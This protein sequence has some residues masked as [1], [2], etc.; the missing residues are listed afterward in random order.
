MLHN[1]SLTCHLCPF[2]T[3]EGPVEKGG[4]SEAQGASGEEQ[5]RST[6]GGGQEEG[7][8]HVGELPAG[9][10]EQRV[11]FALTCFNKVLSF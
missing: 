4:I 11:R 10:G 7:G 9:E 1:H 3:N 2:K 5:E 8:Q 6:D